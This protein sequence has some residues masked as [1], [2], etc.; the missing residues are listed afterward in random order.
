MQ[1]CKFKAS[2]LYIASFRTARD[3]L[4]DLVIKTKS[5]TDKNAINVQ[6]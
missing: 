2:L 1:S 3:T 5:K 4:S 6:V